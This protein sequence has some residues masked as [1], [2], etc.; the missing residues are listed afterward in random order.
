MSKRYYFVKKSTP[1]SM[2]WA[3]RHLAIILVTFQIYLIWRVHKFDGDDT[4]TQ[5]IARVQ[6]K[7]IWVNVLN[8]AEGIGGWTTSL[9]E[10]MQLAESLG[11]TLV[12]PCMTNGRLNQ[13]G[14][15]NGMP[16][17]QVFDL[18][19]FISSSDGN[20]AVLASFDDYQKQLSFFHS[21]QGFIGLEDNVFTKIGCQRCFVVPICMTRMI[22][23]TKGR[24]PSG[25]R[26]FKEF[27]NTILQHM[28]EVFNDGNVVIQLEDYWK[29]GLN[30]LYT[31]LGIPYDNNR[32]KSADSQVLEFHP[33][34]EKFVDDIL[35]KSNMTIDNFSSIHWRAEKRGMDF[36]HCAQAIVDAKEIMLRNI[37]KVPEELA[38]HKFV[39]M[40]SLNEDREKMWKPGSII[41]GKRGRESVKKALSIL[42]DDGFVK[43]DDLLGDLI[44]QD[45]G[46]LAVY[47]LII[48]KKSYHF[49]TCARSGKFGCE[50]NET[51]KVCEECNHIGK[52]GRVAI[53][54]RNQTATQPGRLSW[55]CLPTDSAVM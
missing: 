33:K 11:G 45:S 37:S 9:L 30:S 46:M 54:Y 47:D 15:G 1:I 20:F 24:C 6:V 55:E 16:V 22:N 41:V 32:T 7:R 35:L 48:A 36:E 49:A 8:Y 44:V 51:R 5:E 42:R 38:N 13:C 23:N 3:I 28:I 26:H 40:T 17:S 52:F 25:S 27:N 43:V 4:D 50:S 34:H 2:K 18:Q 12:E 21:A 53:S 10:L 31:L 19:K 39:L 14:D 29:N